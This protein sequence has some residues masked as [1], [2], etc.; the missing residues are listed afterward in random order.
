M[1]D[2]SANGGAGLAPRPWAEERLADWL[3]SGT[4]PM[5]VIRGDPG[6]G[7]SILL[8]RFA[9]SVQADE[10]LA[11]VSRAPDEVDPFDGLSLL[12]SV[13]DRLTNL[14]I[15]AYEPVQ[16]PESSGV[17]TVVNVEQ[18]EGTVIGNV[19]K[20]TTAGGLL[21]VAERL[22]RSVPPDRR[23]VIAI[24]AI[25]QAEDEDAVEFLNVVGALLRAARSSGV[26]LICASRR[27]LPLAFEESLAVDFDLSADAPDD[28]DDLRKYLTER[29]G[30]LASDESERV[31]GAILGGANG[32]WLWAATNAESLETEIA[33]QG[34]V[35]EKL[36]MTKG[37]EGLYGDGIRRMKQRLDSDWA[38]FGRQLL[39]AVSCAL[40]EQLTITELRWITGETPARIEDAARAC[41]PFLPRT[42]D[43]VR[44]FHPDFARWILADNVEGA[45]E[46]GGHLD[47]ARGFT[48][49]GQATRWGPAAANAATRVIEHWCALLVLDPFSPALREYEEELGLVLMDPDWVARAGLGLDSI[50]QAAQM[51]PTLRFPRTNLPLS[52]GLRVLND[53]SAARL[54]VGREIVSKF[55]PEKL[56]EFN[57]LIDSPALGMRWLEQ[58]VEDYRSITMRTL[59]GRVV[60][61]HLTV[62]RANGELRAF[63]SA[64]G[65]LTS[66]EDL[67]PPTVN[68]LIELSHELDPDQLDLLIVGLGER[69]EQLEPE[70]SQ[71]APLGWVLGGAYHER[72]ER[73]AEDDELRAEDLRQALEAHRQALAATPPESSW[74]Q[75]HV[76]EV[77]NAIRDLPSQSE[78]DLD[79]LIEVQRELV[80][81][82]RAAEDDDWRFSSNLLGDAY[83]MRAESRSESAEIRADLELALDAYR[84]A[85]DTTDTDD[86]RRLTF[87]I[88]LANAL[89]ALDERDLTQVDELLELQE[90]LLELRR[91]RGDPMW[92]QALN[93]LGDCYKERAGL[94][95]DERSEDLG[96]AL[97]SYRRALAAVPVGSRFR[98]PFAIDYA[99]GLFALES[100]SSVQVDE[101][102]AI[103]GEVVR[104]RREAD[105]IEWTLSISLLGDALRLR[106]EVHRDDDAA[107]DADLRQALAAY[108]EGLAALPE[109]S[110]HRDTFVIDIANTLVGL[111]ARSDEETDE[112]IAV[113]REIL[114]R[115]REKGED[116]A[117][118]AFLVGRSYFE[119]GMRLEDA[120]RRE[121][122][123]RRALEILLEGFASDPTGEMRIAY[124]VE[125]SNTFRELDDRSD[126]ELDQSIAIQSELVELRRA[127]DDEGWS[128]SLNLLGDSY[129]ARAKRQTD[130]DAKEAGLREA[131]GAYRDSLNSV[132]VEHKDRET[133]LI[134]F[135]NTLRELRSR[136]PEELDELIDAQEQLLAR[137]WQAGNPRWPQAVNLL[138]DA[139][140][141][142]AVDEDGKTLP[143]SEYY[144]KAVAAYREALVGSP[145]GS[146]ER[147]IYVTDVANALFGLPQRT[148]DEL[149]ELI[150][151]QGELTQLWRDAGKEDWAVASS[152]LGDVY[153]ER[154]ERKSEEV[155]IWERD[156][157]RALGAYRDALG[158]VPKDSEHR[159][160][161]VVGAANTLRDLKSRRSVAEIDEL[162]EVQ[163]ELVGLRKNAD[164][165][166]WRH[167][168]NLLGDAYSER[169]RQRDDDEARAADLRLALDAYAAAVE[170]ESS[171]SE[172]YLTF[173]ID[174][175]NTMVLLAI[176]SKE[177]SSRTLEE[178]TTLVIEE[179]VN[180]GDSPEFTRLL[181]VLRAAF[182]RRMRLG[183]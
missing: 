5:M 165:E 39:T 110:E 147:L 56:E 74:R 58:E 131:L 12:S 25:D 34:S 173:V 59:W 69:I 141:E 118:T 180:V 114:K 124:L 154:A 7:K 140:R 83:R 98:L 97:A 17:T 153:R 181:P 48:K 142:H 151:V 106:A 126:E 24:D 70:S 11:R 64:E 100:R 22:V 163:G 86:P 45:S 182:R 93:L 33:E 179:A 171:D 95:E 72:A 2:G 116:L 134:D 117:A 157:R 139:Y 119:R 108:N 32:N 37:L 132:G 71:R 53:S 128:Y 112:L 46:E 166:D 66:V 57:A 169:A 129:R 123:L 167:S 49:L 170:A 109:D 6:T 143:D 136:T 111:S 30:N 99:N 79:Q 176:A 84:A 1:G 38:P 101:L 102:I 174:L 87:T 156:L 40:D 3:A 152:L 96:K 75:S 80:E 177:G 144:R 104:L 4:A 42:D 138:G 9:A 44:L 155:E 103:Q 18:N 76:I 29:F 62:S 107:H 162:I 85:V 10:L 60:R 52:I 183:A 54:L 65:I 14:G 135:S 81:L 164:D 175:A 35:P 115:R 149:E 105:E 150:A 137:F 88:D 145:P 90:Q 133:F 51:A 146:D 21:P 94:V 91:G 13:I 8:R 125:L 15:D 50:E 78:G 120:E 130:P 28:D 20:L 23:L 43:G 16:L 19:M 36:H 168:S 159:L 63:V 158:A 27:K 122:D 92:P 161:I 148:D 113:Q 178:A 41:E 121:E 77:V 160:A 172:R 31:T 89:F 127:S 47:V 61:E 73:R 55:S 67:D 68:W 26:R 82:R